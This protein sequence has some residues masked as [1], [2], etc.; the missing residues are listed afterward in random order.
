MKFRTPKLYLE[1]NGLLGLTGKVH[2]KWF[3]GVYRPFSQE[4]IF[5]GLQ[6]NFTRIQQ[7]S[8]SSYLANLLRK[9]RTSFKIIR[10]ENAWNFYY[11]VFSS[12]LFS[13]RQIVPAILRFA[14]TIKTATFAVILRT[15]SCS[16]GLGSPSRSLT[17]GLF[18]MR[19]LWR[20]RWC[21]LLPLLLLYMWCWSGVGSL[22][23]STAA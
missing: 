16:S 18:L 6:A 14:I 5:W 7:F 12:K 9:I 19:R 13:H 21:L 2:K 4:V 23:N 15:S 17:L 8:R 22:H 3:T 1:T 20:S 11:W 10:P